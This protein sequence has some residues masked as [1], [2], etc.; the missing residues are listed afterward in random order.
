MSEIRKKLKTNALKLDYGQKLQINN[1]KQ[2]VVALQDDIFVVYNQ[3]MHKREC[4]SS[5]ESK[6]K[7]KSLKYET[8][9]KLS[10]EISIR[11]KN[12]YFFSPKNACLG[13]RRFF[14]SCLESKFENKPLKYEKSEKLI[15]NLYVGEKM[16]K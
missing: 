1:F 3:K 16:A 4:F 11:E 9:G 14:L 2:C 12:G 13:D 15:W 7:N 8:S 10:F 6:F 5:S